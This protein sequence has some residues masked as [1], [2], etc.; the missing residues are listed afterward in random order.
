MIVGRSKGHNSI[1]FLSLTIFKQRTAN[2]DMQIRPN[3]GK[4]IRIVLVYSEWSSKVMIV[5]NHLWLWKGLLPIACGID[6][7]LS[8]FINLF[9]I[10]SNFTFFSFLQGHP[11]KQI[12]SMKWMMPKVTQGLVHLIDDLVTHVRFPGTRPTPYSRV[13]LL[14]P[15]NQKTKRLNV[16]WLKIT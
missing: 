11:W 14:R 13:R 9:L 4:T 7:I 3:T 15:Y 1:H 5:L 8:S 12:P 10:S 2:C 6:S 16:N